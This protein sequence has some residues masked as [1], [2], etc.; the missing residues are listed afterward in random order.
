[1]GVTLTGEKVKVYA[2]EKTWS[3][4]TFMTYSIGVASKDKDGNWNNGFLDVQF[5][6]ADESKITNKCK[7]D[8]KNAF[9][10]VTEYNNKKYV[11]WF[12]LDFEVVEQGEGAVG[13]SLDEFVRIDDTEFMNIPDGI[14][15]EVP[16]K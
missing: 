14:D 8:I 6:K 10:V 3:G 2:K 9:P 5:K 12:I 16:F 13:G 11:K 4:G 7:I 1:M 15:E